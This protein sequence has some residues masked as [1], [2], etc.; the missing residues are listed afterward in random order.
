LVKEKF[1]GSWKL[2]S[3][4]VTNNN[5]KIYPFGKHVKGFLIYL[6]ND[7]MAVQ[8]MMPRHYPITDKE[9]L[10]FDLNELAQTL[11]ATGYLAYYGKY[12]IESHHQRII[13]HVEGSIAQPIVGGKEVRHYRF[14]DD[15]LI[16]SRGNM[17]L[18]WV[19]I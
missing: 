18:T 13:H 9:K 6:P 12:E 5:H 1:L 11:K 16:L 2:K 19:K 7:Y 3:V 15:K 8:I 17:E 10:T 14:T 4:I